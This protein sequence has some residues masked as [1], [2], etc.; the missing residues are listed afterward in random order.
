[1]T[2]EF[3]ERAATENSF[4]G[5]PYEVKCNGGTT[6]ASKTPITKQVVASLISMACHFLREA[7]CM[8]DPANFKK[9]LFAGAHRIGRCLRLGGMLAIWLVAFFISPA[10]VC[11]FC[12]LPLGSSRILANPADSLLAAGLDLGFMETRG[13]YDIPDRDIPSGKPLNRS[14]ISSACFSSTARMDSSMR[15]VVGS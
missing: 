6:G 9:Y 14:A 10:A 3:I 15:R 12:M 1:M 2:E 11:T 8:N 7:G 4:S 13:V 5:Q